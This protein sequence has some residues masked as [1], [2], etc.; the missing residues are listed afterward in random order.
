VNVEVRAVALERGGADVVGVEPLVDP[1]GEGD[2]AVVGVD[3]HVA[4]L[5]GFD[6]VRADGSGG[7]GGMAAVGADGAVGVTESDAPH[8]AAFFDP[9]HAAGSLRW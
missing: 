9:G 5:V 1:G 3:E 4:V 2:L 6:G 7:L 8:V